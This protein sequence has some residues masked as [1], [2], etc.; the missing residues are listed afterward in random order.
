MLGPSMVKKSK[1]C[2][3]KVVYQL[4]SQLKPTKKAIESKTGILFIIAPLMHSLWQE[5][6]GE[7]FGGGFKVRHFWV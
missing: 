3:C 4:V 7:I 5:L 1:T 2:T 6:E